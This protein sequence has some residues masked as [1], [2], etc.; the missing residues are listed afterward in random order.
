MTQKNFKFIRILTAVFLGI[1]MAQ[2]IIFDNYVLALVA[3]VGAVLVILTARK[4]VAGT[5]VDE[6]IISIGGR[7][8]RMAITVFGIGGAALSFILMTLRS[9][10]SA[11]EVAGSVLAYSVCVV[12]ILYSVLFKYYEKQN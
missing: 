4:K 9:T 1:I 8:A 7:A 10:G 3:I 6:R 12:L 11:Y 5:L 2:A